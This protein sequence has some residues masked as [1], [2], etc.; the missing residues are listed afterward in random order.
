MW[1]VFWEGMYCGEMG[2]GEVVGNCCLWVNVIE[3][4]GKLKGNF[5]RLR[6]PQSLK[7]PI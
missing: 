7:Y 4:I 2:E 6:I 5:K 3:T 1:R